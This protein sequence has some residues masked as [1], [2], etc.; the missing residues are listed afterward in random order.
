MKD[1]RRCSD[2]PLAPRR[3]GSASNKMHRQTRFL[4]PRI[5][6]IMKQISTNIVLT[7]VVVLVLST[8]CT[9]TSPEQQLKSAADYLKKNDSKSATIQLKNALQ[10]N[11]DLAEARFLLGKILL[12]EGNGSAAEIEFRKALAAKH[13]NSLVVPELARAMLTMG[14]AKKLV[15]EF[16]S[17]K[18]GKPTADASFQTVLVTAYGI[19][20]KPEQAKVALNAALNADPNYAPA[21]IE[22]ARKQA[23]DRDFD[24]ALSAIEELILKNPGNAEAWKLKGDI[25]F[26]AKGKADEALLAHRKSIEANSKFVPGRTAILTILMQQGKL[27]EAARQLEQLK[28]FAANSPQT[29]YLEAQLAYQKKDYKLARELSQQIL[30]FSP[31]SPLILQLAGAVEF[32]M[33]SLAQAENYLSKATQ[34]APEL[35]L[36]R[37]LLIMTYLRSG[38]SDKALGALKTGTGQDALDP[39]LFS[40]AGEVYLQN[41]DA[42]KAEEYFARALKLDP[43]NVGKRTALAI[44]HLAT[45]QTE[46]AFDELRDVAGSDSGTTADLALISAHL[47]RKEFDKAFAAIDK[48]EAKQPGKPFAANLRGG[49]QLAQQDNVAARKSFERALTIDLSNFAAAASLAA[50]D[51]A[52]KKPDDAK[53]RFEN[54]LARNPKDGRALMSLARVAILRGAEK[55]EVAALLSKAVEANPQDVAPRLQLID[56]HI[57]SNETKQALTA[58]QSAILR[59]PNSPEILGAM[60][61]VQQVSGDLNQAIATY[62]KLVLLQPLS[63]QPHVRLAEAHVANKD[64]RAAEQSLHRALEIKP[65]LLDAQRALIILALE[66]KKYADATRILRTIQEQRPKNML[67]FLLEGDIASAQRN[68][69][70]A[71][72]AYRSGLQRIATT[73]LATKLHSVLIASKNFAESDKFAETWLKEHPTDSI[74]LLRLGDL[75]ISRKDYNAAEKYYRALVQVQPDNALALN[76]LAWVTGH[77]K[78]DGAIPYAERSN[79]LAPNQPAFMDTLATL[80]AEKNQYVQSIE[81]LNKALGIQPSNSQLRLNLAK[82]YIK[83]GDKSRAKTELE[84]LSKLGEKFSDQ[85]AVSGLLKGL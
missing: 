58:A 53:K 75:A 25:L 26:Y 3:A 31:N 73:E 30:I 74:F 78:K 60:G 5:Q 39:G 40:L 68:W 24:A 72:L 50:L 34:A 48:L 37:R 54:L 66:T 51:M 85:P 81:L 19:L 21:L 16:G 36:A 67:G 42:K 38:Q 83:A 46:I 10:K 23:A 7:A 27:D 1:P 11:P 44:T 20:G 77:L 29:M 79:K 6:S 56:L 41:G 82:I 12:E 9:D 65:D 64:I 59:M 4:D 70:A 33:D 63:P 17:T 76:N 71:I 49:V 57:K 61:R 55:A 47:S 13:P 35:V 45:G 2:R 84:V 15:D 28:S 69:D 80:L 18:F 14:Q 22:S 62:S 32:Q 43:N 52:D 8:A